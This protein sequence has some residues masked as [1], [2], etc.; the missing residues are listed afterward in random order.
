MEYGSNNI[1][2]LAVKLGIEI[3]RLKLP[4]CWIGGVAVQRWSDPRQTS[5][6]DAMVF[7][8]FGRE[9][10]IASQLLT[11]FPSRIESPLEFAVQARIVLLAAPNGTGI[12]ISLGGLPFEQRI[13]DRASDWP[14]PQHGTIRT[15]SAEDLVVLKAV[16]NRP[17]D[18]I[19]IKNVLI[20]QGLKLHRDL[21]AEELAP[22]VEL[23]EEPEILT[24]MSQLFA[25]G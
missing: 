21:I 6:V 14:V 1:L 4:Y 13:L 12:D 17:Q 23:K 22:L 20:R 18:W 25:N 15:C 10:A 19:D 8:G 5:D 24:S 3:E 11:L 9:R 2:H 7:A 16:A